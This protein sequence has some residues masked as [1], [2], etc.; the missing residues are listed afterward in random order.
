MVYTVGHNGKVL[1]VVYE[2]TG[3]IVHQDFVSLI[4]RALAWFSDAPKSDYIRF[5]HSQYRITV[6]RP[7]GFDDFVV[8]V[9]GSVIQQVRDA[10]SR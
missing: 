10:I 5:F 2:L 8:Q 6:W 4:G 1:P 9:P 3:N 7:L